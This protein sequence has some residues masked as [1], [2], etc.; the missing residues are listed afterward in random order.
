MEQI[1][2]AEFATLTDLICNAVCEEIPSEEYRCFLSVTQNKDK[3][4]SIKA[5]N[6]VVAKLKTTKSSS[7]MEVRSKNIDFFKEE[8]IIKRGEEWCRIGLNHIENAVQ[9]KKELSALY[10]IA[11]SEM[12]GEAFGCCSRYEQCSDAGKCIHPDLMMAWACSYRKHL[13][14]GRI[15]YGKNKNI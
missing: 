13:T 15:F 14:A 7:Y 6:S 4:I 2:F 5:K 10:M 1:S 9:F 8:D 12:G 11:L 3:S